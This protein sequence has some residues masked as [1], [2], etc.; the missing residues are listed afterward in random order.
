M[1]KPN[2]CTVPTSYRKIH[3]ARARKHLLDFIKYTMPEY[4]AGWFAEELCAAL[5]E[6]LEQA[7]VGLSQIGRAHV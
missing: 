5:E 7:I 4:E 3:Q 2:R 6:F 1:R